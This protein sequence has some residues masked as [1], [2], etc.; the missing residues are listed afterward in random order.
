MHSGP[1]HDMCAQLELDGTEE[2]QQE[3]Q[4]GGQEEEKE[5]WL[6]EACWM[7]ILCQLSV[8][9]VC[10]AGRVNRCVCVCAC[11]YLLSALIQLAE[12]VLVRSLCTSNAPCM[13]SLSSTLRLCVVIC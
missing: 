8:R 13:C 2:Q 9:D 6:P 11:A 4:A 7:T 5:A 10:M 1:V 3:Q 12:G